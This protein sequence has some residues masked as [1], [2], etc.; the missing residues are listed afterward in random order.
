MWDSVWTGG[1]GARFSFPH[2]FYVL[3]S[4]HGRFMKNRNRNVEVNRNRNKDR[5]SCSEPQ[6]D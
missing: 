3:K 2:L 6:V 1:L 5:N 4:S